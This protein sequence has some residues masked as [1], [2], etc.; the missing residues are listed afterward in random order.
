MTNVI[1][2][3][4]P[5][6][7]RCET[8]YKIF[9]TSPSRTWLKFCSHACYTIAEK[10]WG[11]CAVPGC[12]KPVKPGGKSYCN[13]HYLRLM[14]HGDPLGG[15][16][17]GGKQN[18]K[19]LAPK[20]PKYCAYCGKVYNSKHYSRS[21]YCSRKCFGDDKRSPFIIKKGYKKILMS[22]HPRADHYGYV[23]EH[24]IILE[25]KLG[26]PLAPGEVSHHIDGNKL[27]NLPENLDAFPSQNQHQSYHRNNPMRPKE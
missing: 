20:P 12:N 24:I 25:A 19:T 21:K 22:S 3:I 15:K 4:M 5:I 8:C 16:Q 9:P 14:R 26:R 11:T 1:F 13:A 2:I 7:L 27:N 18:C 23:F 10:V 17:R 6:L